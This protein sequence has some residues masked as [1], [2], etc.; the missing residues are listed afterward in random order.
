MHNR[1]QPDL[2]RRIFVRHAAAL[3]A[4]AGAG[5]PLAT[6]LLAAGS[7]AAQS[8]ADYR[9]LVCVFMHGGND[10]C[11]TLL[12]TDEPSWDAYTR[13]RN[14]APASI[15]LLEPGTPAVATAAVGSPARL[16]GVLPIA[17]RSAQRRSFALHPLLGALRTLF[18]DAGRLA[19]VANVGPLTMPT[20]KAQYALPAHPRPAS[21]FSH[22]DQQA[23]WQALAPE[24]SVRGW[25]G[26]MGDFLAALNSQ[27]VFTSVSAS[28]NAVWLAGN[29]VLQYQL[30]AGGAVRLGQD[31]NGLVYGSAAVGEALQR[32]ASTSRGRHLLEADIADVAA[33]SVVAE[34]ALRHA[35]R[36]ASDQAFGTP[37]ASG[38]Y[39]VSDDPKLR[40]TS[41]LSGASAAN[42]LAQ[43]LQTVARMIDASLSGAVGVRRQ[44]FFVNL[45]GF[46][47]HDGQN[48]KHADLM[49]RLAHALHYFDNT[50]GALGARSAV[51]TF[52]ASDFGR[53]FTSNGDGTDHGWGAH[54]FVMGGAVRGGDIYG[55]FPTLGPKNANDNQFDSSP[56]QLHNGV[57]LP[58]VSVDQYGATLGGWFGLSSGQLLDV[59]PNLANFDAGVRNLGFMT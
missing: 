55:R 36:P 13:T 5:A 16:G 11:N 45:G 17:P 6:S 23:T 34:M 51:T 10:A 40:Y 38:S 7:V 31:S 2:S 57:L 15:A 27:T 56:D 41:P 58:Q 50:L 19:V 1:F 3:G 32:I 18:D 12:A 25:G 26:R 29:E 39:N 59:F 48:G 35:L 33:R 49:A 42:P 43:Q 4:L 28:G 14:Q 44:L 22:N 46:D 37:P 20:T 21:L 8:A 24:G 30:G 53:S 9:A 54:H 52:T 47:T